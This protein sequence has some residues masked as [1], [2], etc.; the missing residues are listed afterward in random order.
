MNLLF[1]IFYY[2]CTPVVYTQ[3]CL[4]KKEW[5]PGL[6]MFNTCSN[7]ELFFLLQ[8]NNMF[9]S[10]NRRLTWWCNICQTLN[11]CI[12]NNFTLWAWAGEQ[13]KWLSHILSRVFYLKRRSI[14]YTQPLVKQVRIGLQAYENKS[15]S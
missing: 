5:Q 7:K 13:P 12:K 10:D 6:A 15:I 4:Y 3:L 14:V 1:C 11:W 9:T 2:A 8:N